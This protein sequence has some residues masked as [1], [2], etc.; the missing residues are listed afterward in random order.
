MSEYVSTYTHTCTCVYKPHIHVHVY[1][2]HTFTHR[3]REGETV[4]KLGL[5]EEFLA[6][7]PES[8]PGA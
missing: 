2:N 6:V 8:I 1:S 4:M 7:G 3:K 5:S